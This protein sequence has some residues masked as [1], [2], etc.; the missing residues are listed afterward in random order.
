MNTGSNLSYDKVLPVYIFYFSDLG[1]SF[2]TL[3]FSLGFVQKKIC[4]SEFFLEFSPE[5]R[6]F[7]IGYWNFLEVGRPASE[8]G[9]STPDLGQSSPLV[10]SASLSAGPHSKKF[11]EPQKIL[12]TIPHQNSFKPKKLS[13]IFKLQII[14]TRKN[15]VRCHHSELLTAL[16]WGV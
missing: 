11:P 8:L 2:L 5:V 7:P 15:G 14:C 3:E 10:G 4:P 6:N 9:P 13:Y 1:D 16:T 12:G